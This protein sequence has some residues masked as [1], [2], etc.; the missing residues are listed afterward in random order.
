MAVK[1]KVLV[2]QTVILFLVFAVALFLP[3]GTIAWLSG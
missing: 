2:A 3:A 1:T